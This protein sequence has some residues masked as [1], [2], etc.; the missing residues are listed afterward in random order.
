MKR[1]SLAVGVAAA[2][3]GWLGGP[4]GGWA[5][6]VTV[7][8]LVTDD[9]TAHA[10]VLEDTALVNPWGVS[11][12]G[13]GS[14]FWV[15]DNGSGQSTLYAVDPTTG[16]PSKL[17]L[18]VS[19][20]G[21]GSVT[22]QAF[23]GGAAG[24]FNSDLFLFASEDGTLSGWRGALGTTAE[25][26]ALA[27]PS[28]VYKGAAYSNIN[29]NT[30]LYAANFRTGAIDVL[31]GNAGAPDLAGRFTDPGLPSG[32]APFNIENL[33]GMMYVTYALQDANKHDD[34]P[35]AGHGFVRRVR[36]PG[37][38]PAASRDSNG[39][40]NSPWGLALAPTSFAALAGDLL[41]G[42]FGDGKIHIYNP[43]T[44]AL[45]GILTGPGD[46]PLEIDGLWDLIVGSGTGNGGSADAIYFTAG[47]D[48]ETHGLFGVL[49]V[50]EPSSATLLALG[51]VVLA[52]RRAASIR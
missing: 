1:S 38:L 28:N 40:L 36:P 16:T 37:Q 24:G 34:V 29:G 12:S 48:G 19:I 32:Y 23:A 49:S 45:D 42:N 18:N 39:D 10:A 22:G 6:E 52:R 2:L 41:V 4:A 8:N 11:Q 31:K 30:Y 21:A 51:L 15:S 9:Q 25:V 7:T 43:T 13:A 50:P 5:L 35:G 33:G 14:P 44:G 26:L 46:Q 47:P 20:P 17:M 3:V 27:D